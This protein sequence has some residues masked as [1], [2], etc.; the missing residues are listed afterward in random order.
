[1]NEIVPGRIRLG[2]FALPVSG[3]LSTVASLAPGVFINPSVDP[4]GFAQ[5]SVWIGVGNLV[6]IVGVVLLLVGIHALYSFLMG[7]ARDRWAL[8]GLMFAFAGMGLFLPFLGIFAFAAPIAG[9]LYLSGDKNAV[10]IIADST[11]VSSLPAFLF[12]G[13]STLFLVIGSIL[14]GLAIW[15]SHRLPRWSGIPFLGFPVSLLTTPLYDFTAAFLGS[16]LLLISGGWIAW[17]VTRVRT[18]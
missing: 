5:A 14:F 2:I 8:A 4:A 3:L 18:I 16:L 6:G 1:M 15:Q 12:G 9:R 11:A 17:S 13:L 10:S 7:T